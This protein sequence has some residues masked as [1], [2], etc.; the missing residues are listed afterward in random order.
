MG[1]KDEEKQKKQEKQETTRKQ[2]SAA[3]T[4]LL[5]SA[6]LGGNRKCPV[7]VA[8]TSLLSILCS[9]L[10]HELK[11]KT[12]TLPH[13]ANARMFRQVP[14]FTFHVLINLKG[15][16]TLQWCD[17]PGRIPVSGVLPVVQFSSRPFV[18]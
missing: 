17:S 6:L 4:S 15:Q 2:E 8:P 5:L 11:I 9:N 1:Q 14:Y 10:P 7:T 16:F 3:S 13:M 12:D 18:T